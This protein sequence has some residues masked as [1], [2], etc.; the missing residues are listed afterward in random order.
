MRRLTPL[1]VLGILVILVA[2]CGSSSSTSALQPETGAVLLADQHCHL[3]GPKHQIGDCED[4]V[5]SHCSL[6]AKLLQHTKTPLFGSDGNQVGTLELVKSLSRLHRCQHAY[7]PRV[8][9]ISGEREVIVAISRA[10]HPNQAWYRGSAKG[11]GVV[12]GG[13]LNGRSCVRGRAEVPGG[14]I[15]TTPKVCG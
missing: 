4:P 8:E 10:K 6:K 3:S 15:S 14:R 9:G 12:Y 11:T 5:F 1:F 13:D 2:G 7:W